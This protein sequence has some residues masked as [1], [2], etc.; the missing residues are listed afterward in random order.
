M[1]TRSAGIYYVGRGVSSG[2]CGI[3]PR[4]CG[5]LSWRCSVR[6][7][8]R[9]DRVVEA[10]TASA[11]EECEG[12]RDRGKGARNHAPRMMR[13]IRTCKAWGLLAAVPSLKGI[14]TST[15]YT[16][17]SDPMIRRIEGILTGA[18][19]GSRGG[20]DWDFTLDLCPGAPTAIQ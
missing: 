9:V 17:S 16:V 12:A 15:S 19:A 14:G 20:I 11:A 7:P 6:E 1:A 4:Q 18:G 3:A 13:S 10:G 5:V 8:V 2:R